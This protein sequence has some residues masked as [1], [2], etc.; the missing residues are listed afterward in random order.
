MKLII[1]K[2]DL[3]DIPCSEY[4]NLPN[5]K[6]DAIKE[7]ANRGNYTEHVSWLIANCK[8][9]QT[10]KMLEYFK[11]LNPSKKDVSW[12]MNHYKFTSR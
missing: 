4:N 6:F 10:A 11:S 8:L 12:L 9:A 3:L 7:I 1:K 5:G 2:S